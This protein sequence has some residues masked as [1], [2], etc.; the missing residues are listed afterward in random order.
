[1]TS[2]VF[3]ITQGDIIVQE[4]HADRA[5]HDGL[6]AA[7]GPMFEKL[8]LCMRDQ[9]LHPDKIAHKIGWSQHYFYYDLK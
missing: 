6:N 4:M 2:G 5:K 3:C 9:V 1:M 8:Y 7:R